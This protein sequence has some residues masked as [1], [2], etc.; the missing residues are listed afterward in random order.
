MLTP[1]YNTSRATT[2]PGT[3]SSN[4][5]ASR[6]GRSLEGGLR[7][8]A[9][10]KMSCI[11]RFFAI[12]VASSL[13]GSQ[14]VHVNSPPTAA[15]TCTETRSSSKICLLISH[16]TRLEEKRGTSDSRSA[17]SNCS[18]P[19]QLTPPRCNN[20][21]KVSDSVPVIRRRLSRELLAIIKAEAGPARVEVTC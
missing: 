14:N 10:K 18:S 15:G 5:M 13:L 19:V 16:N 17:F 4:P 3:N 7:L 2:N 21:A 20:F 6:Q 12:T 8:A 9:T 1:T 11:L